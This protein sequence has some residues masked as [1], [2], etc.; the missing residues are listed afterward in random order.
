MVRCSL[1]IP[2]KEVN[3]IEKSNINANSGNADEAIVFTMKNLG[4]NFVF[5][6]VK[7]HSLKVELCR[8]RYRYLKEVK[9]CKNV[10]YRYLLFRPTRNI[11]TGT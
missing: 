5:G 8:Y 6:Q 11:R 3:C 4:R 7:T 9:F 1:V 10:I 2:L